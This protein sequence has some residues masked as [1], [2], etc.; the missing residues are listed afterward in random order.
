[1]KDPKG[2]RTRPMTMMMRTTVHF[3]TQRVRE[4]GYFVAHLR[5]VPRC[6]N[7]CIGVFGRCTHFVAHLRPFRGFRG[8]S[9]YVLVYSVAVHAKNSL[10]A[11]SQFGGGRHKYGVP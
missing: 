11:K 5:P 9:M 8:K 7:C 2:T 10:T 1:V 4:E 6:E 3:T